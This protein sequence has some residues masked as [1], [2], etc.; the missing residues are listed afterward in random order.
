MAARE[1]SGAAARGHEDT[2]EYW[3]RV[4][5]AKTA[6]FDEL[7]Q[8]SS[9]LEQLLEA[10]LQQTQEQAATLQQ[11]VEELQE[12][13]QRAQKKFLESQRVQAA[14]QVGVALCG[15]SVHSMWCVAASSPPVRLCHAPASRAMLNPPAR[16]CAVSLWYCRGVCVCVDACGM[17]SLLSPAS[18]CWLNMRGTC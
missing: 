4:A 17:C 11:Q 8:G 18:T 7:A 13:A 1:P 9:E 2:V 14:Q 16:H 15:G 10:E 6:E 12:D 5:E 3:R